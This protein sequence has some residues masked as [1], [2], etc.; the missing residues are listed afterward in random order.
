LAAATTF[1]KGANTAN[2]QSA[3]GMSTKANDVWHVAENNSRIAGENC[4][5]MMGEG[6]VEAKMACETR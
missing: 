6:N 3:A 2:K 1:K 4:S 5:G